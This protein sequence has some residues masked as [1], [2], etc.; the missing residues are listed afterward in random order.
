[1]YWSFMIDAGVTWVPTNWRAMGSVLTQSQESFDQFLGPDIPYPDD[2]LF[3]VPL[4]SEIWNEVRRMCFLR[5]RVSS[6]GLSLSNTLMEQTDQL[7]LAIEEELRS[8]E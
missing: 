3:K 7:K 4:D 6:T 1:M 2:A 5:L 8:N